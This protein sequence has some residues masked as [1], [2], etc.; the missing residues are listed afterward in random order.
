MAVWDRASRKALKQLTDNCLFFAA[1]YSVL[2]ISPAMIVCSL[3]IFWVWGCTGIKA[4]IL[5]G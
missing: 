5:S 2:P 4:I 1:A 3:L